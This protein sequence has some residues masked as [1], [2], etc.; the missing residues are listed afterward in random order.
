M[1]AMDASEPAPEFLAARLAL[2]ALRASIPER[3]P[4]DADRVLLAPSASPMSVDAAA[5]MLAAK[6][7]PLFCDAKAIVTWR[8]STYANEESVFA[9]TIADVTADV[10]AVLAHAASR[11]R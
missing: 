3:R 10:R 1:V 9:E 11:H 5:Q 4:L 8:P 7:K 2:L 6:P